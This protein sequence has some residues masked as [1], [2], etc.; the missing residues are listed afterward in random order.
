METI[1]IF[2]DDF[3]ALG[4]I[5]RVNSQVSFAYDNEIDLGAC[6]SISEIREALSDALGYENEP[7]DRARVAWDGADDLL[8]IA[9][10]MEG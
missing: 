7:G 6:D 9:E 3:P 1:L 8:T 4:T 10:V 5:S 2:S